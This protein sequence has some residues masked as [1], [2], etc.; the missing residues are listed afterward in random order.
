MCSTLLQLLRDKQINEFYVT[1]GDKVS[2]TY[3]LLCY[4]LRVVILRSVYKYFTHTLL[5]VL[6]GALYFNS[7]SMMDGKPFKAVICNG[8]LACCKNNQ[9]AFT[10]T[11]NS[12]T[13]KCDKSHI[14]LDK[15]FDL[16]NIAWTW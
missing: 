1:G 13:K 7:S 16:N 8:V 9:I 6:V 2:P 14:N 3:G 11:E 12:Q 4:S 5:S 15:Q 10:F